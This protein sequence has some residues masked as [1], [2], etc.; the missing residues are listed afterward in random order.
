MIKIIYRLKLGTTQI[1]HYPA[2][3]TLFLPIIALSFF[4]WFKMN[5]I[6]NLFYILKIIPIVFTVWGLL[7]K[8]LGLIIPIALSLVIIYLI[9]FLTARKDE[10]NIQRAFDTG[11]LRNGNPILIYKKKDKMTDVT[12][13]EFYSYIPMKAWKNRKE[14]IGDIMNI[15]F[16][17]D[18]EYGGNNG[19]KIKMFSAKGKMPKDRGLIYDEEF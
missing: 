14:E 16:I 11:E 1:I 9:G 4:I 8:S 5:F 19:N 12:V 3:G 17:K 7:L 6:I 2:L 18:F 13:R 10:I 15:H